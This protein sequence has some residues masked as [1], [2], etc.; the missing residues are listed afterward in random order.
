MHEWE[1]QR[2][3][4]N[5]FFGRETQVDSVLNMGLSLTILVS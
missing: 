5:L 1:G 2:G 4:E 3:R